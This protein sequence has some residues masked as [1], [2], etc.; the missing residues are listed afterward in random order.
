MLN[1]SAKWQRAVMLD[2]DINVNCFADIVTASG[3]KIPIDDSELWANGFEVN[4]STSSNGTFTIGALIAGKL[5]IKLNNIYEDYSKYDFDKASVTTYISKSFSDGTTEKLKIGEYR[6]SETSYDGSL[7]TLTC[8]DNINN[9]NREYDSNLSYPTTSYEVVRDA[10]IKCDVP[11][12][13]ARFDNSDYVINEIPSDNQKLTYGQVIAYI[14][15]LSGLWGK[16]GHDGELLIGWYDMSQ[17]D[18]RSYNGGTFNTKTTPYSDG[19]SV[20]GG[21]FNYSDGDNADGGTFAEARNYHNIY[22][23]KDLNVATDD[24]VI[25]GVKVTVTSKED[26]TKDVNVLAGKEGYVIS[27]SDNPFIPADKAQAVA[28]YIFKKIGGM[29]FRPLDA[30]LL[31]NPLI[32][33]GDVALVT[34]RKQNTYSCFISNRT[35]T[36]GSG[37]KISC[38]AENASRNSAD[39]FSNETKAI[40]QARKVAQT[41]LSV[42]DKQMQLLTQ[43]MSQSLGLFKTEQV[44]EDGSII[45]IMHNKADLNSSN[46]QWKMTA[47]GM[48]VSS[49]YGKTWNAGVDKDGNAVFNIMSA[50]GINF[51][52][53]HGGTLTLGGENNVSGV[54]Y[55]K[56]AKGKTLVILDNKGLTLDSSVK[57]A[58]DNVAEATAKVTQI[59][60]DTV[61]TSYVNALSV[62]AGSVDAEDITGTTITGKNI[63]GGTINIGSGVFAVDSDGKVTASNLN[64]SG[65][66][67]AL[68]GNLS[69]STIDLT[70]TDNSGNNYELWM[71][72]AVLRIVKNGE[73]LIT[74]YGATGSIGAQT[75]YAQ[76]IGSDKFRETDRGYAMC[77]NATGHTYHCDWDDTALWFQVDDAWVWSSSDKRLKKNIKAINQDY[78]DAVGSVDLFQYNLNRQGYSDKPLYFGAMA[79]DIIENLKDKGH[80]DENL[81]MIFKNKVTSDDDTLYYGMNYEQFIIL[82]LAGDEQKIDKMQKRIDE[83]EDKFSR[84]CQKL[85]IDE[86]EV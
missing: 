60:K 1:V 58:W 17:F 63:V 12:T 72:G 6:V 71:N 24:V 19:D 18:S 38:D 79:Q 59:T 77:G 66:S 61:T 30:T 3:E 42:Y 8:L 5:K 82:R 47:N 26:K 31:S 81:N 78:I 13:M 43:L 83:L 45:Y 20:D 50:I 55:V 14:L 86:S 39:K 23:Q 22:T 4:D 49:D 10:C 34:D 69:N 51:D 44:Q 35:F 25:T 27:I 76:E 48:A 64:M 70:A 7:I 74:L 68:N 56:D 41:Q 75:V 54:Q 80:A 16:C 15:Q 11:F 62:K 29:R 28:N 32:E 73:N 36:I 21:T 53:A 9:F 67:I 33:S 2:N 57:I 46:I 52:W 37:T 84:L 40:V 85:G 65:G